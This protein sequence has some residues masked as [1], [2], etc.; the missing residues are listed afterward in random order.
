MDYF[1]P[2]NQPDTVPFASA[3]F[4]STL[5]SNFSAP[6]RNSAVVSRPIFSRRFMLSLA[7]LLAVSI[8]HH[9]QDIISIDSYP[10]MNSEKESKGLTYRLIN[11]QPCLIRCLFTCLFGLIACGCLE[12]GEVGVIYT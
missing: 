3:A 4:S 10:E 8:Y 7:S 11:I 6:E 5:P 12:T 2:P 9:H 1:F